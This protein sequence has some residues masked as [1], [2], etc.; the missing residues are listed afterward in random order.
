MT[1][2]LIEVQNLTRRFGKR[3]EQVTAVDNVSLGIEEG[4]VL[5]LVG[6]SGCG[7]TTTGKMMAGLLKPSEGQI[8]Y[9]GKNVWTQDKEGFKT[10]RLGVQIIHQDPY[11]SLNPS[12]TIYKILSV[13]LMRHGFVN[14][15]RGARDR[16]AELLQIVD[17]TPVDDFLGKYPHQLSGGQRQRVSVARALTVNPSFIVADEAV[18]MVD[19][20][21]RVSLLN[22]LG[23]LRTE[24]GVTFLFIT[25]DLALAKFFAWTGRIA[26][27]YVGNIVEIASTPELIN[28]AQ[29]PYT[30]ALLA[31]VPEADPELTRKKK[32]MELRSQDI[33]SLVN[34]PLGC[35]FNP[36]CPLFEEG[37]CD[38]KVPQLKPVGQ[39]GHQVSCHLVR[40]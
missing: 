36:R 39:D 32:P 3:R 25:H 38:E 5:C 12:H 28:N 1:E 20:S 31:A 35:R 14:G 37:L 22:M 2:Y 10:Y 19:V 17:L 9:M 18:S 8:L 24:L 16:V 29:H 15:R 27:M 6:E 11:A 7:K 26:V 34:L 30:K 13:P 4:E 21:I 40:G 33:P 23:R